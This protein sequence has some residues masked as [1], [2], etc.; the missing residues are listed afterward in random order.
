MRICFRSEVKNTNFIFRQK[1]FLRRLIMNYHQKHLSACLIALAA[2]F[3]TAWAQAATAPALST[4][5]GNFAVLSAAP[6]SGGAVTCTTST[7]NGNVGSSGTV[8][9]TGCSIKGTVVAPVPAQVVNDFNTA[10]NSIWAKDATTGLAIIPCTGGLDPAP[11]VV[12]LTLTPGVY[13]SLADVTFTGTTLILDAQ[14]DPNA[15]WI[16][17]I[18]SLSTSGGYLVGTNFTV[19]M[20]NGGQPCNVYWGVNTY[21]TMT[22]SNFA[23]TILAGA[24]ITMTSGINTLAG[25]ALATAAVT[26]TNASVIGCGALAAAAPGAATCTAPG[27]GNG[28]DGDGNGKEHKKCN[29]GGGN[30]PEGCDPGKSSLNSPFDSNDENGGTPG[31]RSVKR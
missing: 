15:V 1:P 24:A 10:Y 19:A 11:G 27:G 7:I 22:D 21:A 6:G 23:G 4:A 13:C 9:Q 26:M 29:Q 18:G 30:G 12:T 3:S 2:L 16:F 20:I 28:N 14:G 31:R 25:R 17:K 8:T 5:L